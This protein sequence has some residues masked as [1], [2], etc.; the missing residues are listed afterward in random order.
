ML[1]DFGLTRIIDSRATAAGSLF[2]GHGCMRW[3]APEILQPS[4]DDGQNFTTRTDV[5]A[6]ACVM[7]EVC[8]RL[9]L[10]SK[11]GFTVFVFL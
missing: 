5:Y 10:N 3:Q 8:V 11:F 2:N 4:A 9:L 6:L 1:A 7:L